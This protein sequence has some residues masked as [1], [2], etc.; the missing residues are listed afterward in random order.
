MEKDV[1]NVMSH[2]HPWKKADVAEILS[3]KN[4]CDGKAVEMPD[5]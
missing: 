1:I 5:R 3:E 2:L 4:V